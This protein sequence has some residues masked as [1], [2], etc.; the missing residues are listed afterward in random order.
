M[1][2]QANWNVKEALKAVRVRR[3]TTLAANVNLWSKEEVSSMIKCLQ[4][5]NSIIIDGED[6]TLEL[7]MMRDVAPKK[8]RGELMKFLYAFGQNSCHIDVYKEGGILLPATNDLP[9]AIENASDSTF[10]VQN[11]DF[12]KEL[13]TRLPQERYAYIKHITNCYFTR[14]VRIYVCCDDA[15]GS[16]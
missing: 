7:E 16:I 9:K 10:A 5:E 3:E 12:I 2:I 15:K 1:F 6:S 14:R 8:C 4:R 13:R 11:E